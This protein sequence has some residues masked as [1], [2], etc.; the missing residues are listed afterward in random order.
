MQYE[1]E[2]KRENRNSIEAELK[3]RLV[4][5][6][7]INNNNCSINSLILQGFQT[8]G[9]KNKLMPQDNIP[10]SLQETHKNI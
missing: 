3:F 7:V 10:T 4:V 5:N 6:C 1:R 2:K 8:S 9:L